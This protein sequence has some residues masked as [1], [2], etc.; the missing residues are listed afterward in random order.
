MNKERQE[1]IKELESLIKIE[2]AKVQS[3]NEAVNKACE[4]VQ[5]KFI[6]LFEKL[7]KK[8]GDN[9]DG[10]IQVSLSEDSVKPTLEGARWTEI[11]S[12]RRRGVKS[13]EKKEGVDPYY[14][15]NFGSTSYDQNDDKLN[16][17]KMKILGIICGELGE[18]KEGKS[19]FFK[20]VDT[21]FN[22]RMQAEDG[23]HDIRTKLFELENEE[24]TLRSEIRK[25]EDA[26]R[27]A[28]IFE[29]G[30]FEFPE[31]YYEHI[32]SNDT[33][34]TM[35]H[36]ITFEKLKNT[37]TIKFWE[38]VSKTSPESAKHYKTE[39]GAGFAFANS[40]RV[41]NEKVGDYIFRLE[42][43][44]KQGLERQAELDKARAERNKARA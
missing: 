26:K 43:D 33:Y 1:R 37:T 13:Y 14:E 31:G 21:L 10:K 36:K 44:Y 29:A 9:V 22:E 34:A 23:K 42:R 11:C 40:Y 12:L 8:H 16:F 32:K 39:G 6:A 2:E 5:K 3:W 38:D 27:L 17:T 24:R 7:A 25:E 19:E 41:K 28:E 30:F 20:Q 35:F 15:V 4:L 18:H